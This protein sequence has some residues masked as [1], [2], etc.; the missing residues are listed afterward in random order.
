[1][2]GALAMLASPEILARQPEIAASAVAPPLD[3]RG[4]SVAYDGRLAI[5]DVTWR[6][7]QAGLVAIVGPNGAGKSTLLKAI[8]GLVPLAGGS[9]TVCGTPLERARH[10][11]AYVP[12][13]AAVDWEFPATAL[14]VV[15]QGMIRSVGW[16]RPFGGRHRT[17]ARALLDD[18]GMA[19]F[20]DRQ[21]GA[22]SGGQQQRV[23]LARGLARKAPILLFD[24]P[25]SG[26]DAASERIILDVFDALRARGR[27]VICVHHDL[28]TVADRFDHVLVL[29]R[30]VIAAGAV[31]Q[32]FTPATLAEAYGV[33]LT[34]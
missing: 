17:Q 26:V 30:R 15:L 23:F 34:L 12:Q 18:V 7:P 32:A 29:N 10:H 3:V 4:L 14:D 24:E 22:L 8:L 9:V 2:T 13:R 27:L 11:L 31:A 1:M 21:I 33:P 25:L 6:P 16:F 19:D 28:G 5:E 20:A